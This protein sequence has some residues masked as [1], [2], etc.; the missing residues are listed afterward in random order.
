MAT[1]SAAAM[2]LILSKIHSTVSRAHQRALQSL[3][4]TASLDAA[5]CEKTPG[6][7]VRSA[8]WQSSLEQISWKVISRVV[9][10]PGR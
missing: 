9:S 5:I 1:V 7:S 6:S 3:R 8:R 4:S 10:W 2:R